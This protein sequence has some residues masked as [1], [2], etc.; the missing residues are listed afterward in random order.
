LGGERPPL[1]IDLQ[2]TLP[3]LWQK[4]LWGG[5]YFNREVDGKDGLM[6]AL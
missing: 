1:V 4:S 2:D 3:K 5:K 6:E